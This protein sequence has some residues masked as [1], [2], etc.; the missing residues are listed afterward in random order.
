MFG[1]VRPYA[2][3]QRPQVHLPA[4]VVWGWTVRDEGKH[5][6]Y[7]DRA[8]PEHLQPFGTVRQ[9]VTRANA[10]YNFLAEKHGLTGIELQRRRKALWRAAYRR[11]ARV[12]R[13]LLVWAA[14]PMKDYDFFPP[15]F[16]PLLRRG[17][18][19][20]AELAR[21]LEPQPQRHSH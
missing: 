14:T 11:G 3:D 18:I 16:R 2:L 4:M 17:A 7:H 15:D 6:W 9:S 1:H 20:L 10:I 13:S 21:A 5:I 12:F 19:T 8:K